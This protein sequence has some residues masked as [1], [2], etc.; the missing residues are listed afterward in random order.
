MVVPTQNRKFYG[1]PNFE[2]MRLD[3]DFGVFFQSPVPYELEDCE[4]YV[5][6][7]YKYNKGPSRNFAWYSFGGPGS[8]QFLYIAPQ[9]S[10]FAVFRKIWRPASWVPDFLYVIW[11]DR[12][13]SPLHSLKI[14]EKFQRTISRNL[15][16]KFYFKFNLTR[17]MTVVVKFFLHR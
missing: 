15:T 6:Y 13:S 3:C 16:L 2:K 8:P 10:K 4:I 11:N 7:V 5:A 1:S 14:S 9:M 17:D 12:E